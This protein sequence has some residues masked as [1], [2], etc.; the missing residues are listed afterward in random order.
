MPRQQ[1]SAT[2]RIFKFWLPMGALLLGIGYWSQLRYNPAKE[3]KAGLERLNLW[4]AQ[5]G[6]QALQ[7]SP[8]LQKAAQSHADF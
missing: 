2:S 4:R 8:E 7:L 5:A 1:S 3:A 6:L